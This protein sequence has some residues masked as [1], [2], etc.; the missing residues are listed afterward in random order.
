MDKADN[1]DLEF[2]IGLF[3]MD[4]D[5]AIIY[6]VKKADMDQ[7]IQDLFYQTIEETLAKDKFSDADIIKAY[8]EKRLI[9]RKYSNMC[10][11]AL[12]YYIKIKNL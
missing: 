6:N 11:T 5:A 10:K 12:D 3:S 7:K 4:F 2:R 8:K 9:T 1:K